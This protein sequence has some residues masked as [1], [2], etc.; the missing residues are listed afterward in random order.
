MAKPTVLPGTKLLLLLGDGAS[1]ETFA[2]PCGLTTKSFD[3]AASTNTTVLPDCTDPE[4]AAWEATDINAL[5]ASGAG[6]GVMAVEA[7]TKW[8][9]WFLSAEGKNM[10][11]KLDHADLGHY[12][13]FFKLT[14]FKLAGTRGNKVTVDL[15]FKN[16]GEVTWVDAT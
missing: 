14:S 16:D 1:P 3:L 11:I 2:E 12:A 4:A 13:G 9:E 8:N 5:S 10:Q 7:F 15:S 6:T